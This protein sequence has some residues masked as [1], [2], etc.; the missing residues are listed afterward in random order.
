MLSAW[1]KLHYIFVFCWI[2]LWDVLI[3]ERND[4]LKIHFHKNLEMT[5]VCFKNQLCH[6]LLHSLKLLVFIHILHTWS[7]IFKLFPYFRNTEE[8]LEVLTV[9]EKLFISVWIA[10]HETEP[11]TT[12]WVRPCVLHLYILVWT[13]LI[14]ECFTRYRNVHP[15]LTNV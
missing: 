2:A 6:Q 14:S 1:W 3:S 15:A 9:F 5:K 10:L 7:D 4:Y 13:W 11:W 8:M 12:W